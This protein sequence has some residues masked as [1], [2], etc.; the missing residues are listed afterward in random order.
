MFADILFIILCTC[1]LSGNFNVKLYIAQVFCKLVKLGIL[2]EEH[3]CR[4]CEN[5]VLR[6]I[7]GPK[8]E[9]VT[10]GWRELFNGEL[11]ELYFSL[12]IV[13]MNGARSMR[14]TGS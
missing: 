14:W 4:V 1:L 3:R 6:R 11:Y 13:R 12:D 5:R 9:E 8:R 7:F 2:R 10:G